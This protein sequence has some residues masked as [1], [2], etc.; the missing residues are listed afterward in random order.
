MR[1]R[2]R[3]RGRY[4]TSAARL[5][6][7]N[8]FG[9][10]G[11]HPGHGVARKSRHRGDYGFSRQASFRAGD[12]KPDRRRGL[13]MARHIDA[14]R[15]R[16]RHNR[17][18]AD[19]QCQPK[20]RLQPPAELRRPCIARIL[21]RLNILAPRRLTTSFGAGGSSMAQPCPSGRRIRA[22]RRVRAWPLGTAR[23][24][25]SWAR[26]SCSPARASARA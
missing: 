21:I 14:H 26:N 5:R 2:F 12:R 3:R 13:L 18:G 11:R 4:G 16:D 24:T 15:Q 17:R 10:R 19:D 25:G 1:R 6:D 23:G 20:P 8:F 7:E 22:Q 9:T